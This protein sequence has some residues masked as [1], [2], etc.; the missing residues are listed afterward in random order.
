METAQGS[1]R[2]AWPRGWGKAARD[3]HPA[4]RPDIL[5]GQ[6]ESLGICSAT[7]LGRMEEGLRLLREWP[8]AK[9]PPGQ[10]H[11]Q[12]G[13]EGGEPA[14]QGGAALLDRMDNMYLPRRGEAVSSRGSF[15]SNSYQLWGG[16]G[17][18][19][20][21]KVLGCRQSKLK[22][23]VLKEGKRTKPCW[24]GGPDF[25]ISFSWGPLQ[26]SVRSFLPALLTQSSVSAGSEPA[27]VGEARC[28]GSHRD[29]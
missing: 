7:A 13:W 5:G 9:Q 28:L 29:L 26:T 16:A 24:P 19:I 11:R 27:L 14:V 25:I 4:S 10:L 8:E 20:S 3:P 2:A 23:V 18:V 6:C 12:L 22:A 21:K 15:T 17:R 1:R